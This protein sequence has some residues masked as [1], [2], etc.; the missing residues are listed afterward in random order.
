MVAGDDPSGAQDR[1]EEDCVYLNCRGTY[2]ISSAAYW[3]A[4]L[5]ALVHR[6][7]MIIMG[8]L[9]LWLL[10]FADDWKAIFGQDRADFKMCVRHIVDDTQFVE[11]IDIGM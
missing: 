10:L 11:L 6:A 8:R 2:G 4:R 9:I 7:A 5:A 3:G 1:D